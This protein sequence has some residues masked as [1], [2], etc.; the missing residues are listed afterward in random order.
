MP[1]NVQSGMSQPVLVPGMQIVLEAL[2][3]TTGDVITDVYIS[4]VV[5]SGDPV[6]VDDAGDTKS[7]PFML[8]P[9]TPAVGNAGDGAEASRLR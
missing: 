2:D 3:P 6:D 8:V 9:G 1:D 4:Q 7:G 5:I